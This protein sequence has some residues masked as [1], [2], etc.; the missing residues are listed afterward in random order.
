MLQPGPKCLY[1]GHAEGCHGPSCQ[2]PKQFS[3]TYYSPFLIIPLFPCH[4][5][6]P[7]Q[8]PLL[9]I[10][11]ALPIYSP[12]LIPLHSPFIHLSHSC[13]ILNLSAS[14]SPWHIHPPTNPLHSPLPYLPTSSNPL[15]FPINPPL[16]FPI[17]PPFIRLSHSPVCY[18]IP[19]LSPYF[20]LSCSPF[21]YHIPS[22]PHLAASPIP[23]FVV[24]FPHSPYYTP[25]SSP[26]CGGQENNY[27]FLWTCRHSGFGKCVT[28][29]CACWRSY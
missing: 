20:H 23:L 28:H 13:C 5:H 19:S 17:L 18:L 10:P 2:A 25:S 12:L 15:V 22:F 29:R 16:P 9:P 11:L 27:N 8:I 21:R 7:P 3:T 24:P 4:V 6:C 14:H 1:Q 26:I